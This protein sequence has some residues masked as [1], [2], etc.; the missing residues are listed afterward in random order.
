VNGV[1]VVANAKYLPFGEV[2]KWTW[3]NGQSYERV[4]DLDGR[5]KS[6]TLAGV[7]RGYGFDEAS[8]ITAMEDKQ[9]AASVSAATF[10]YD[11]LDH[12]TSAAGHAYNELFVYDLIGNRT[13]QSVAGAATALTYGA[14]SNRLVQIGAQ[15]IGYDAVVALG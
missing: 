6:V 2:Q 10:G 1:P 4:Y 13:S 5:I 3:G 7:V 14:S 8:R 9:G 11:N 15:A 12:L